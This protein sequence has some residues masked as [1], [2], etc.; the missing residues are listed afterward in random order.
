MSKT[1]LSLIALVPTAVMVN[2]ERQVIPPGQPLPELK[3]ADTAALLG[4]KAAREAAADPG[5]A[6]QTAAAPAPAAAE[7][8]GAD[9]AADSSPQPM[10]APAPAPATA[11]APSTATKSR[12]R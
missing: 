6:A 10:A 4:A 1:V 12:K 11:P 9:T 8:G 5:P 2:G 3:P 7:G